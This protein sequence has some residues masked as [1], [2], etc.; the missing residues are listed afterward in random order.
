MRITRWGEYGILCSIYLAQQDDRAT[1][2]ANEI[3]TALSIPPQY[4]QQILRRLRQ[5]NIIESVRGP[6]GGYRL[7][8]SPEKISLKEILFAA[9]GETFELIC[10]GNPT[11]TECADAAGC[12]ALQT[13]WHD[14]KT[15]I[16]DLLD[17]KTLASIAP[18]HSL[19]PRGEAEKEILTVL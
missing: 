6:R 5:G 1:V 18:R 3:A 9:E 8:R 10:Q 17:S 7:I 11:Y 14:L 4:T 16:D 12:C 15:A 2:G 19:A 13:V